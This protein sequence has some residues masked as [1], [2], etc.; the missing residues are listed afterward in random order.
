[1]QVECFGDGSMSTE[2]HPIHQYQQAGEFVVVLDIE[3]PEGKSRR[4]KVWD[5]KVK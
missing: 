3:G 5:V 2:Q 1:M 4:S